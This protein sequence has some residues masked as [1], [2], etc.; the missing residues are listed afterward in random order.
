M[1]KFYFFVFFCFSL[2]FLGCRRDNPTPQPTSPV[3]DTSVNVVLKDLPYQKLSDYR[4]FK[5]EL[6]KQIPNDKVLPYD[7]ASPLFTDYAIK[8]RYVW[9]PEGKTA[10]YVSDG[11]ILD[12][13]IGTALVKTFYFDNVL[14]T[15]TRK[16][17][18]TRVMVNT[19]TGWIFAEYVWNDEQ[20]EAYLNMSGSNVNISWINQY[21]A[22][23]QTSYRVPSE[24]ECF[25]CHKLN[26]VAIPI[27]PKPQNLNNDYAFENGN[28]NQLQKW[29]DVGY[30]KDDLPTQIVSTIN[31]YD[32]TKPLEERVRSYL[33]IS[34]GHCHQEGSHC[35]YRPL[36][37]AYNETGNLTNLGICVMPEEEISDTLKYIIAPG[38]P[39]RSVLYYRLA[40]NDAATRMPLI[41]RTLVHT[42]ALEMMK[43]WI[44]S[45]PPCN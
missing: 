35:S 37:L 10:K 2:L 25:T 21:G 42:E 11:A 39:S 20:T 16:I 18:E 3:D 43:I 40:T 19:D 6:Q 14:P 34:C 22:A 7:L 28:K 26:E 4:F 9:M 1:V 29:I 38:F 24:V 15:S 12:M 30:L 27:G 5:G 17:I 36:R 41:G 8:K 23:L 45:L 44:E 33:D 13:P 32:E 31:Y